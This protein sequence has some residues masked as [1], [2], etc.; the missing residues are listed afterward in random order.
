[1]KPIDLETRRFQHYFD[2]PDIFQD[3]VMSAMV[4]KYSLDIIK[5]DDWMVSHHNYDMDKHGSLK[6]FVKEK[7]GLPAMNF[8]CEMLELPQEE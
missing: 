1:M 7:F 4:G 6:D 5:L 2:T 3:R 8:L